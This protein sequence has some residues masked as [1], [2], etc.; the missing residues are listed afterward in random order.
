LATIEEYVSG[1]GSNAAKQVVTFL[2]QEQGPILD[3]ELASRFE[4]EIEVRQPKL[5]TLDQAASL[6]RESRVVAIGHRMC[7]AAFPSTPTTNAVYLDELGEALID[8]KR[9]T[10]SDA[11]TALELLEQQRRYPI[12][13]SL[14][15]GRRQEICPTV[16]SRCFYWN[17]K[18]R[19]LQV[20]DS[21]A[22][23]Q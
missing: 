11:A 22:G 6:I 16:P 4:R 20:F 8:V 13:S 5:L 7:R 17:L 1:R 21:T 9:A 19:Q 18:R 2:R 3:R 15:E 10:A 23:R 14:V 12:V